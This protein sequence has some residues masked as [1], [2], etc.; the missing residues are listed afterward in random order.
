MYTIQGSFYNIWLNFPIY[1]IIKKLDNNEDFI[2]I[3]YAYWFYGTLDIFI[4]YV[5]M[6]NFYKMLGV[7]KGKLFFIFLTLILHYMREFAFF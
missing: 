2:V 4:E 5:L 7:I 1:N 6:G 3:M